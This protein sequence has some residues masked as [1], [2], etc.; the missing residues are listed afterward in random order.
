ML[1]GENMYMLLHTVINMC[2]NFE[3]ASRELAQSTVGHNYLKVNDFLLNF[4]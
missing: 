2:C 4:R 1:Q 3:C